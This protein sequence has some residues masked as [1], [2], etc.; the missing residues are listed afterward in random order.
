MAFVAFSTEL[1]TRYKN[2]M[3]SAMSVLSR[4]DITSLSCPAFLK[5]GS[6]RKVQFSVL[7]SRNEHVCQRLLERRPHILNCEKR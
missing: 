4:Y 6:G 1:P 3:V 5:V 7:S 2:G